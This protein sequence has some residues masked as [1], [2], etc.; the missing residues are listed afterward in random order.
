MKTQSYFRGK[1]LPW[2]FYVIGTILT[3]IVILYKC[4]TLSNSL[5]VFDSIF[6]VVVGFVLGFI[7]M[8]VTNRKKISRK[9]YLGMKFGTFFCWFSCVLVFLTVTTND[10]V[11][12]ISLP[13]AAGCVP[14]VGLYLPRYIH[15]KAE[16]EAYKRYIKDPNAKLPEGYKPN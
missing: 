10:W 12:Y 4:I 11:Y 13:V 7:L 14:Y 8:F 6:L 16:Q 3:V 9:D 5:P 2:I 1:I 15:L